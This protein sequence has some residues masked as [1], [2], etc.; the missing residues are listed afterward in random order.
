MA[1]PALFALGV[2]CAVFLLLAF[3]RLSPDVVMIGGVLALVVA[4]ILSID[5]ALAGLANEGIAT[6]AAL[7]IV[8]T[9]VRETGAISWVAAVLFGRPRSARE[10]IARMS[11]P[12]AA[13]SAFMN[14]T[15]LVAM[16][17]PAV[18]DWAKQCRFSPSK[19]MIPLSYA[20]ILGGTCTL[21]G[22]STNLV[23]SGMVKETVSVA[24]KAGTSLP[25]GLRVLQMF[26][27]AWIGVPA[28]IAGVTYLV[29]FGPWLLPDRRGARG[30]FANPREYTVE[31]LVP[32]DSP[33]V[34]RSI[35]Q[36]GLRHLP[37]TF[38][39]EID[40]EG[41]LLPAVEPQTR[42]RANDRLVFAGVVES[43]IDL[44]R[45]R[46]LT[47]ATN[48]LFKL[49]A[50]RAERCLVEAV[51]SNTCPNIGQT[52]RDGKF[53]SN[54]KAVVV[55]VARSGERINKKIGDIVLEPGDTLLLETSATWVDD[56]RNNRDFFLVSRLEDSSPPRHERAIVS[57]V[58]LVA[59]ILMTMVFKVPMFLAALLAA[60]AM[61]VTRCCA[62]GAARRSIDW[63]VLLAIAASFALSKGLEKTGAAKL[64]AESMIDLAQ[65]NAWATLA[66]VYLVTLVVTEIIT[67]NAAAALMF[68]LAMAVA[69]ELQVNSLS[70]VFAVMMAASAGFATPIGYQTNLMV[71]GPGGYRFSDYAKIGVPLDILIGV[72]TVALAPFIWPF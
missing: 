31:M 67:N 50:P 49:D 32:P 42:L 2:V 14:N 35:E 43:V 40:R 25:E 23:V 45:V 55:A 28:A 22:T 30:E 29:V 17:I 15:P 10:A 6:I 9:G 51:V 68:P 27:V 19:V 8:V 18:N 26:D 60:A 41:D 59:M 16:M 48:Q 39:I 5:E 38:L 61:L 53:R 33:L 37:G 52:I 56:H 72:V 11:V 57:I 34:G 24:T 58:I 66:V 21:I 20:T 62:L 36:A 65:G 1:T 69:V 4:R 12:V 71:Y 3:T 7:Y 70:F 44:Q 63:E 47:P 46:G 54:Y 64:V 13:I